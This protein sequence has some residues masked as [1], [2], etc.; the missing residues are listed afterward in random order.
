MFIRQP[1]STPVLVLNFERVATNPPV[2]SIGSLP[3]SGIPQ[4]GGQPI[5]VVLRG[6]GR[7][8]PAVKQ[9]NVHAI[10]HYT[11]IVWQ[12]TERMGAAF[13][14]GQQG[15]IFARAH[16]RSC[17][18]CPVRGLQWVHGKTHDQIRTYPSPREMVTMAS[19]A[20]VCLGCVCGVRRRGATRPRRVPLHTGG[21]PRRRPAVRPPRDPAG[22]LPLP[23]L[24]HPPPCPSG[25][26]MRECQRIRNGLNS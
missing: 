23:V 5:W 24:P 1:K 9:G 26:G 7:A 8:V 4:G 2:E 18:A 17:P 13:A 16:R 19:Q 14:V 11:Q 6:V 25:V 12:E 21:Q 22:S 20:R 3:P 15:G 10:G